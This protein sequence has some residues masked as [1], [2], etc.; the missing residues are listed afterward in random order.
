MD[1]VLRF[2]VLANFTF[3]LYLLQSTK[4]HSRD[5]GFDMCYT[6]KRITIQSM[7]KMLRK[8]VSVECQYI[9]LE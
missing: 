2:H 5:S 7:L 6:L 4:I 8:E 3:S 1:T 9:L